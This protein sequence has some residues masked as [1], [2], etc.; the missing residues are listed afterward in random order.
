M[1]DRYDPDRTPPPPQGS[2]APDEGVIQGRVRPSTAVHFGNTRVDH[3]KARRSV[4]PSATPTGEHL[5]ICGSVPCG[6]LG[7][8]KGKNLVGGSEAEEKMIRRSLCNEGRTP[9]R[10]VG[11]G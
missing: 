6:G 5:S 3:I 4:S 9:Q 11:G 2:L 1:G 8:Y 10:V 7:T